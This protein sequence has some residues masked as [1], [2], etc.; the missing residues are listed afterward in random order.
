M[1]L[2]LCLEEQEPKAIFGF[3]RVRKTKSDTFRKS[4]KKSI[5]KRL[6][7]K[8][9]RVEFF[10]LESNARK[11]ICALKQISMGSRNKWRVFG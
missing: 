6:K 8:T 10:E 1:I 11:S 4:F 2:Q 9:I 7:A 3:S 5:M